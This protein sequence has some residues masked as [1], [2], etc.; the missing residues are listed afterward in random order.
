MNKYLIEKFQPQTLDGHPLIDWNRETMIKYLKDNNHIKIKH[1][2]NYKSEIQD[3]SAPHSWV[4]EMYFYLPDTLEYG[5]VTKKVDT[6]VYMQMGIIDWE[7]PTNP[8]SNSI[9]SKDIYGTEKYNHYSWKKINCVLDMFI[10]LANL[11]IPFN[12]AN[13]KMFYEGESIYG[14]R[15]SEYNKKS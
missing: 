7:N 5:S 12:K 9:N 3:K 6:E 2:D 13:W 8:Y 4:V 10:D 11:K 14:N 1:W 15:I